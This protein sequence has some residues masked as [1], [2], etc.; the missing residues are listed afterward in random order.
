[1]P[2]KE[3]FRADQF[4]FSSAGR[5]DIDVR[6]LGN[7]RP[8]VIELLNPRL[9]EDALMNQEDKTILFKKIEDDI[10]THTDLIQVA[11]LFYVTEKEMDLLK[12]GE[13][14][15]QKTYR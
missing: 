2:L 13:E 10:N 15:K 8:F 6:M 3:V 14:T 1:M 9:T 7:G 4:R 11:S 12:K 5:E